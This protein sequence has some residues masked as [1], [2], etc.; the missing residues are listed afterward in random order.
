MNFSALSIRHPVPAILL[1]ALLT[2]LGVASFRGLGI[3][4]FPDIE[5]PIITVSAT[6]EGAA[7]AQLETEV[8]RRIEDAVASL[9]GV[10]H[11]RAALTDSMVNII[12][13]F[14]IDKNADVALNEVRNAVDSIRSE[15]PQDLTTPVI[16]KR[17]TTGGV[18]IAFV[19][20]SKALDEGELS[21]LVDNEIAKALLAVPGV[22]RFSRMGGIDREIQ[23]N[24][25]PVRMRSLG[26]TAA[27]LSR[28]LRQVRK[29]A[30]G[31]RGDI[32]GEVQTIRT[33][34]APESLDDLMKLDLPLPG[35]RTVALAEI[36]TITDGKAEPGSVVLFNGKQMVGFELSRSKGWSE[37]SVAMEVRQAV[38]EFSRTHPQVTIQEAYNTFAPAQDNFKGS[39]EL[40]YEGA[41]LAIV[42]VWW[43][44][45]D[46][47]AT[48][49]SAAALPLSIIPA[50][51]IM[52]L[53]NF[54]LDTLTLLSLALVVGI[55]VDDAIVEVENI[56]R[57]LKMGKPPYQAAMEAANEI[58]MAVIAT[59]LTLVAVFLPT[60]FMGGIPGKFFRPFGMTSV[61]AIL[62]SLVV[63][64][65]LTPMM[66]AHLL[67][68]DTQIHQKEALWQRHYI[69]WV[70]GCLNH[71]RLTMLAALLFFAGSLSLAP[72]LPSGFVPAADRSQTMV[73]LELPPGSSLSDTLE[74]SRKALELIRPIPEIT[75]VYAAVGSAASLE[76][77]PLGGTASGDVRK[78]TLVVNLVDRHE[79]AKKQSL[80]EGDLR[81]RL[82]NLPG[83][84]V[85]INANAM[86]VK[87]ML[88]LASNDPA[89]LTTAVM[90]VEKEIR[91]RIRN[92]G[93]ILSNATLE[94]P[95]I[96]IV[97]DFAKAADL[98]IGSEAIAQAVRVATAGDFKVQLAKLNL[99]ERQIP[100]R[101]RLTPEVR[102]DLTAIRQLPVASRTGVV[103]LET[104]ATVEM[105]SGAT[106]ID[107]FD[108]M[109]FST[110][111]VELGQ[112]VLGEVLAEVNRLPSMQNLPAGVH[113]PPDGESQRMKELFGSFA[114]AMSIGVL[115]IYIVLVLLFHDFLQPITILAALP[116]SLGGAFV[117][118]L[119]THN[120]FSMPAVIG[121]LMLMGIVTKNSILLVEY[122]VVARRERGLNRR[123]ALLDACHKR[124]R[125]IV[126]TT[127]AMGAGM[128]P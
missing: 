52:K 83:V 57:H 125:P 27:D 19:I 39:M 107:R 37:V 80:V 72:L 47:R 28:L 102:Q 75:S 40:L 3:Q 78:A 64:R 109:R 17:T 30:P 110:I 66:S 95:E 33:M 84:R 44:L 126:M 117:A 82:Q 112:R 9:G 4:N 111:T 123:D 119:V 98:G 91:S 2:L 5:V 94:R 122:A 31:G 67:R 45:R 103:P 99:P 104:V 114:T 15:L 14:S 58:G 10:E 32:A 92:V 35:G 18:M 81:A 87:L 38:R 128:L 127:I 74:A 121:I 60:A 50:F 22:G 118:L 26:I 20:E 73:S 16:S 124:A 101:V 108:R 56:I 53:A 55:L 88:V 61:A 65:L 41:F 34:A 24:L 12:I 96:H 8:A 89:A 23:V 25:D 93:N 62:A 100:I 49:I 54:S 42:V 29:D 71:P 63:A 59:T 46:L 7:P 115:C 116:L 120:A 85:S 86:G 13:E 68:P 76:G 36:A 11:I 69:H 79:R 97:P 48:F 1:F 6:L 105:E 51:L 90:G 113:R 43:F 106:Q 21:W 77:G 70:T